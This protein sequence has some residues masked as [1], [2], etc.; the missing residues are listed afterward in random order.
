MVPQGIEMVVGARIDPLFGPL[1]V[2]GLGGI[3]VE[4]LKDTALAPAPVS[5]AQAHAML[6]DLKGRKLLDGFRN[7]PTVDRTRLAEIIC[8]VSECAA[9]QAGII[10]ELDV[11]PVICAGPRIT[12]VDALIIPK[13]SMPQS[14]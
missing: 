2:V 1:I 9:D 10:A 7:L 4:L 12:A 6:D 11:N 14:A 8:R 3:L 13:D 5:T